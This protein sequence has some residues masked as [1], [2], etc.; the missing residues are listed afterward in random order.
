MTLND[1]NDYIDL[2]NY[3]NIIIRTIW[4]IE[5]SKFHKNKVK[6]ISIGR[7]SNPVNL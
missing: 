7:Y 1:C 3:M 5:K 4:K 2:Y 6:A